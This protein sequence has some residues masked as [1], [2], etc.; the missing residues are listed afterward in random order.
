MLALPLLAFLGCTFLFFRRGR[1]CRESLLVATMLCAVWLFLSTEILSSAN[2][3]LRNWLALAWAIPVLLGW[4]LALRSPGISFREVFASIRRR[5]NALTDAE[6]LLLAAIA[7]ILIVTALVAIISPPNTWDA[8]QYNMPRVAIWLE[9]HN[10]RLYATDD[11]QQLTMAPWADYSM[12]L[13]MALR[14]TDRFVNLV[15]WFCFLGGILGVSLIAEELGGDRFAQVFA[16]LL[17]ATIP[18]A[19]L[20]ASSA[21]PDVAVAFWIVV[22]IYFLLRWRSSQTLASALL[23]SIAIGLAI[24]TKGTAYLLLPGLLLAVFWLWSSGARKNFVPYLPLVAVVVLALNAPTFYRNLRLSGSPLG[25]ASPD[26]EADVLG[27]RHF[28]TGEKNP[29]DVAANVLRNLA[30]HLETPLP[31]VNSWTER[32]FRAAI[33]RIGADPDDQLMIEGADS[34]GKVVFNV[35]RASRS[36][37]MAGNLLHLLLFLAVFPLLF[38]THGFPK[39]VLWFLSGGIVLAFVLFC[40]G[41]RWQPWNAR[42]HLPLFMLACGVIAVVFAV[43]LPRRAIYVLVALLVLGAAPYALSNDVR[44]LV[45]TGFLHHSHSEASAGIF[46]VSRADLRFFDQR[47]YLA[48]SYEQAAAF[49]LASGC[50]NVGLDAS[51]THYDYPMLAFLKTGTGGPLLSYSDIHN[52]SAKFRQPQPAPCDVICLG[53][54]LVYQKQVQYE[55]RLPDVRVFGRVAVFLSPAFDRS[56]SPQAESPSILGVAASGPSVC[57]FFPSS[58]AASLLPGRLRE[59]EDKGACIF[60]TNAGRLAIR[61]LSLENVPFYEIAMEGTGS[62]H[63]HRDGYDAAIVLEQGEPVVSYVRK[64]ARIF[65][66]TIYHPGRAS[67]P[68]EFLYAAQ[69]LDASARP[70]PGSPRMYTRLP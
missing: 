22:S 55:P 27:Q 41:L 57:G 68:S 50:P 67:S 52:R 32:G 59:T 62:L 49:V 30:L 4:I 10:V 19:I 66:V 54:A 46:A 65:E 56:R 51:L 45:S 69:R 38:F 13:V 12:A 14:G 2:L 64:D 70:R 18:Q 40:A 23:V 58:A 47:L 42:F 53:C 1:G 39:R 21:K 6:R 24:L 16:A 34:G 20:A 48:P 37:V 44:P 3:L 60:Q 61:N 31:A 29:R 9:H 17:C 33:R 15:E 8:M 35:P 5:A 43:R 7:S 26:G 11:Y 36:E 28:A 25:F 63:F